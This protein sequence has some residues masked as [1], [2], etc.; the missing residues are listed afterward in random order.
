KSLVLLLVPALAWGG[1]CERALPPDVPADLDDVPTALLAS[2]LFPSLDKKMTARLESGDPPKVRDCRGK[3]VRADW[4][5]TGRTAGQVVKQLRVRVSKEQ[6][7]VLFAT[8]SDDEGAEMNTYGEIALFRLDG[9][10]L[11]VEATAPWQNMSDPTK[12]TLDALNGK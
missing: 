4:K 2:T 3:Q 11:K 12:L 7:A 5:L 10:Q 1:K 8:A 9:R 6:L